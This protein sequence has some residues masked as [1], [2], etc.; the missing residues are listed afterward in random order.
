MKRILILLLLSAMCISLV[1]CTLTPAAGSKN[2]KESVGFVKISE[3]EGL[4]YDPNTKIVYVMFNEAI[5]NKGY[6]YMSAYY[7]PNG[8]PYQYDVET[9][10]LVEIDSRK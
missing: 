8:L 1:S 3:R 7:A 10:T 5:G 4:Y 2:Y 9:Q 6:G